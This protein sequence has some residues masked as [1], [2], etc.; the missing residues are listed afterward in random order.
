VHVP[1]ARPSSPGR[2]AGAFVFSLPDHCLLQLGQHLDDANAKA[3]GLLA[4]SSVLICRATRTSSRAS[5]SIA[6]PREIV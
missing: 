3:L 1:R 5:D 6:L 2:K 4:A